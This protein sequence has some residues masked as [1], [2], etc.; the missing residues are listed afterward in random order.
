[1]A[2]I[3][4]GLAQLVSVSAYTLDYLGTVSL[5]GMDV[6]L[7]VEIL[8]VNL[9]VQ[10]I[11]RVAIGH[12]NHHKFSKKVHHLCQSHQVPELLQDTRLDH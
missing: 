12:P 2:V 6:F 4:I 1:M 9:T 11:K 8:G 5:L 7:L 3:L 10:C